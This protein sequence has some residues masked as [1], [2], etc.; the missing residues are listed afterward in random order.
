MK[1]GEDQRDLTAKGKKVAKQK[2]AKDDHPKSKFTDPRN[3]DRIAVLDARY[4]VTCHVEHRPEITSEMAV[5]VPA[6]VCFLCHEG[7]A[8]ERPSHE[9]M[10]CSHERR[11]L[12]AVV[13]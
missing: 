12:G 8:E 2:A 11:P 1:K 3:A 9:G 6:D 7:I 4:C 5:T 10:A 13:K